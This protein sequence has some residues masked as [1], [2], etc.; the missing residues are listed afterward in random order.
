MNL[1]KYFAICESFSTAMKFIF[2]LVCVGLSAVSS[3]KIKG[4]LVITFFLNFFEWK[5]RANIT[6][7]N[8]IISPEDRINKF[9]AK[10]VFKHILNI[11]LDGLDGRIVGGQDADIAKYGYQASLQ[12]FNE[13][14]CGASILNNYWIVTAA[15]CI[16]E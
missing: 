3:Y 6:K 16:Y 11:S 5:Y 7:S 10:K 4:M 12:V 9:L 14:F 13:H 8:F 15:H 2:V 1:L